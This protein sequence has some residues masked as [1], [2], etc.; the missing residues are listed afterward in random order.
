MNTGEPVNF[1]V[2]TTSDEN[3]SVSDYNSATV[4]VEERP[5]IVIRVDGLNLEQLPAT[6]ETFQSPEVTRQ[7]YFPFLEKVDLIEQIKRRL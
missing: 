2:S 5:Q 6:E 1:S 7:E 4:F 3:L